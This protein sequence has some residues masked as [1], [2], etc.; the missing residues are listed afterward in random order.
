MASGKKYDCKRVVTGAECWTSS[1]SWKGSTAS[2]TVHAT[3]GNEGGGRGKKKTTR[4]PAATPHGSGKNRA[5]KK[6]AKRG[7][8]AIDQSVETQG[9]AHGTH[10]KSHGFAVVGIG[11]SAG[12][13][14]ALISLFEAMP[15]DSGLA[16]VLVQHLDPTHQSL[17]AELIGRH[18]QMSVVEVRDAMRPSPT[19]CMSFRRTAT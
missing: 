19:A 6:P 15:A 16:F 9:I 7:A 5:E 4:K 17:S 11:A 14:K 1:S 10:D 2:T 8:P 3:D 12:G 18:T 13:L